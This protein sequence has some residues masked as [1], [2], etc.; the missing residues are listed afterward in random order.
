MVS[1][2]SPQDIE[3]IVSRV[4]DNREAERGRVSNRNKVNEALLAA[5]G[6]AAETYLTGKVTEL[7]L[8]PESLQQLSDNSP[9]ALIH[10]LGLS[11]AKTD[12][13]V[14]FTSAVNTSAM[15]QTQSNVRNLKY[16]NQIRKD[17]G[18]DKFYNDRKLQAQKIADA[19]ELG[20]KFYE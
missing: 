6:D 2:V 4:T 15:P 3:A 16:Y 14:S 12:N 13:P 5:H 19:N 18:F 8:T 1:S 10:M 17:M 20:D 11:P 7:G 9:D